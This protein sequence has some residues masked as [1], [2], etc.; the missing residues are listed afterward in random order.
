MEEK[1]R[2]NEAA[3]A[4]S[5]GWAIWQTPGRGYVVLENDLP[6]IADALETLWFLRAQRHATDRLL[7]TKSGVLR[8]RRTFRN[9]PWYHSGV[10]QRLCRGTC[11]RLVD[12]RSPELRAV[13]GCVR[14]AP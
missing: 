8:K 2:G 3:V 10:H 13:R 6:M 4:Q 5:A 1:S 12:G 9:E 14:A 11:V 7:G